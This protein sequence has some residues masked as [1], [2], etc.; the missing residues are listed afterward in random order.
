MPITQAINMLLV[1]FFPYLLRIWLLNF[2]ELYKKLLHTFVVNVINNRIKS[3]NL[4]N[5]ILLD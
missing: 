5:V 1:I 2:Q 3:V 4:K